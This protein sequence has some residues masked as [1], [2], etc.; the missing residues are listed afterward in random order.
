[1]S[2]RR[3]HSGASAA[4]PFLHTFD[5]PLPPQTPHSS[6]GLG[7]PQMPLQSVL[8]PEKQMPSQPWS[9]KS[10][11]A[12]QRHKLGKAGYGGPTGRSFTSLRQPEKN[13]VYLVLSL[14]S[15]Y[16]AF[17]ENWGEARRENG[18]AP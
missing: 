11:D 18:R 9:N 5:S 4:A 14:T 17:V 6:A 8:R 13:V 10:S 16:T 15:T 1:M 12:Q 7:P 3:L 2:L